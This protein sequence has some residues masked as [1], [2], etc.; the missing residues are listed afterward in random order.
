VGG[1]VWYR[2]PER[3][4][5]ADLLE[6]LER[7]TRLEPGPPLR[8][9]KDHRRWL[10]WHEAGMRE[11]RGRDLAMIFQNPRTALHPYFTVG[12]AITSSTR[13][14][15]N[16]DRPPPSPA[17]ILNSP[18]SKSPRVMAPNPRQA[19]SSTCPARTRPPAL[20][21]PAERH[22][23]HHR[24]RPPLDRVNEVLEAARPGRF[25]KRAILVPRA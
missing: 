6:G 10:R 20:H 18:S 19:P 2:H 24:L 7:F 23:H 17:T 12:Q 1:R 3:G 14:L 21:R 22:H 5:P 4:E 9:E 13:S 15:P 25:L 11:R 16:A 8:V